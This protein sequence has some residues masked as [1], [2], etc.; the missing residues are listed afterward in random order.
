M[1]IMM[2]LHEIA[3]QYAKK[4]PGMIDCILERTPIL[5]MMKWKASTHGLYNLA[6]VLTDIKGP[7]FIK[8]DSPFPLMNV[9]SDIMHIDLS[10]MGGKQVVPSMRAKQMG[11]WKKYFA[12][13]QPKILREMGMKIEK[14]IVMENWFAGAMQHGTHLDCKGTGDGYFILAVRFDEESNVGLYDPDQ[15]SQGSF[16]RERFPYDGAEHELHAPGYEGIYGYEI[17]YEGH[18]GWQMLD[19]AR[20]VACIYNITAAKKPTPEMIDDILLSVRYDEGPT[21]LVM[22][23]RCKNIAMNGYKLEHI[24][25]VNGDNNAQTMIDSWN[26]IPIKTSFNLEHPIAHIGA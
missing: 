19:A 9:S 7:G 8:P 23:P 15:F 3:L 22:S 24:H 13:K 11:G 6:E 16:L 1:S 26:G 25:L 14:Q 2:T 17:V 12:D 18:F 5:D 10:V 21:Y 4:Q 20:T